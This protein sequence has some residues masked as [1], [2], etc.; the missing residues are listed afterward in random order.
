MTGENLTAEARVEAIR[1]NVEGWAASNSD[2]AFLLKMYDERLRVNVG[3]VEENA[4]LRRER[5][6]A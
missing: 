4:K 2:V 5:G 6:I 1:K 3:L